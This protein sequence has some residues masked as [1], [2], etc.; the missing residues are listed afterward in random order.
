MGVI[1][2]NVV[3]DQRKRFALLGISSI[4]FVAMIGT[5]A[6]QQNSVEMLCQSTQYQETCHKSLEKAP[7]DTTDMKALLKAAFNATIDELSKHINNT[8]LYQE[9]AKDNMTKQAI[10]VCNEVLDY[11]VDGMH[12]SVGTLDKFDVNKVNEYAYDLKV[13][14]T[15]T[16]SHQQTC[17]DGFENSK[18][19]A[20]EH[21]AKVLNTSMALSS[22]AIDMLSAVSGLLNNFN[23]NTHNRKLLS[24]V[25]GYPSWVSEGQRRLL[26][27]DNVK[28]NAVV[29]QDG[30]GQFKTLTDALKTVPANN[31][32]PFVIHVKEGVY[33][34]TVNVAKEMTYVTII[35]DGP[36]KTKFTGSLNFADGLLPYNTATFGVNG[37]NFIAKDVGF[38]NTAGAEKHQAV[39]LRV[40]ADQAIIYN[41]QIDGYQ[42]TLFTESQRQFFRDCSISGTIDMV[43][44][45]AF[46]IFQNCKLTIRKPLDDQK[47]NVAA[48]GRTK[49]DSASGFVFQSCKFTGEPDVA[50]ID[51]KISYLGRPWKAYSKVVIMDSDIDAIFNPEGY[52]PWMG[53]A[54]TDT[55]TFYE[56]NN[57]GDGADTSKRVKWPGVKTITATE[58]AAY[59]PGKF[60]EL[61]NSSDKDSWIVKSEV[62]YALGPLDA[63]TNPLDPTGGHGTG[64]GAG[65]GAKSSGFVNKGN[66]WLQV[67]LLVGIFSLSSSS[68][69]LF[70]Q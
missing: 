42:A 31:A 47:C 46:G 41:C 58:A 16:L 29:A 56:Y 27:D 50:K 60:F 12:K 1:H 44:G 25:D 64:A 49:A 51:P 2:N 24:L 43:F 19:Q 23:T 3:C 9:L 48:N 13:W 57:K 4:L 63:K 54:F 35:G 36:T 17:L 53:S 67:I 7:S 45:D 18:T 15:G 38:E 8:S 21:M 26:A 68:F 20:G 6:G 5:V 40:T 14:L 70:S 22:N 11:A 33:T 32:Q 65:A 52:L 55:C 37:A 66:I 39:A 61:A 69:N 59:Y 10:E 62:P 30:S 28:P 34:E